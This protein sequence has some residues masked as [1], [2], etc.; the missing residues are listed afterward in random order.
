M[1]SIINNETFKELIKHGVI[2]PVFY[3]T[4]F[5]LLTWPLILD[6]SVR[7]FTDAGDG[8]MNIWNIWWINTT[9]TQ[10]S[11]NPSIWHTGMLHFPFGTT[12]LG[13]TLNPFNG[14]LAVPL[15]RF[16]PLVQAH[17]IIVLFSFTITGI[18]MYWLAYYLTRSFWG[19]LLAGY[20]F[21]F[22]SYHFAHY[23]G[24]L[25]LISM[26][27]IP[28]FVLCWYILVTRPNILMALASTLTLWLVLLCDYYYFFYCVLAGALIAVWYMIEQRN[29][30][31]FFQ[32]DYL[33]PFS[34]FIISSL[35]TLGQIILPLMYLTRV[36]P[37][38][39]AHNPKGFSL[40]LFGLFIPGE[41]WRFSRWTESYWSKLPLGISEASVYLGYAVIILLVYLWRKRRD[42]SPAET[43]KPHLWYF[44]LVF[45]FLMAL[46][47]V[48]QIGGKV[49]Y[50]ALMP[51][52]ILE[53]TLPFLKLSGVPARMVVMVT[54]TASVLSAMAF[55]AIQNSPRKT[56]FSSL[57]L[58][59]LFIEY[60]PTRLPSTSTEYPKY[61]SVLADLPNDGGVL[62]LSAPNKY[63]QVYYQ[64]IHQKPMAFGYVARTPSSLLEKEKDLV[65]AINRKDYVTLW[66]TYHIRYIVTNET[67]EYE[68]P[69]LTMEAV[70]QDGDVN[71]YRLECS[72]QNGE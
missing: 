58:A 49:V 15:L 40:D 65:R 41:S 47:P 35:L 64:T 52:T 26:E 37:F 6:F 44:L 43:N 28:L 23:Y 34:I 54:L 20:I 42:I 39:D 72:C 9:V 13:Q 10:P 33:I 56:L 63:S 25:N 61:V 59:L 60:L 48:L 30:R 70:Y 50:D 3:F 21:T 8:F 22:S 4:L 36:D 51:Y 46:G 57:I 69:F 29:I 17:N 32:R 53:K 24:H 45:F 27:W 68:N 19:S 71:I 62:D 18:T 11:V 31:L 55:T 12:L 66:D 7:F 16:M 1:K 5:C 2:P 67:I 14:L 38:M